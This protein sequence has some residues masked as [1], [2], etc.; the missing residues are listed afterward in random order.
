VE[1]GGAMAGR[2]KLTAAALRGTEKRAEGTGGVGM[3][4]RV[5]SAVYLRDT[6]SEET[7]GGARNSASRR[8]R[9]GF[10]LGFWLGFWVAQDV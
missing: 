3:T 7:G 9:C 5:Q 4:G 8:R 10:E 1:R 2:G 6:V